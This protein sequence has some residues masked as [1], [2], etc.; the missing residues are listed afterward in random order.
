M[1]PAASAAAACRSRRGAGMSEDAVI[2]KC[3]WR[4]LPLIIVAYVFNYIDRTN[5]GFAA[6]TMNRDLGFSP[7][8]YG[9]GAGIFFVSYA[10]FQIPANLLLHR[11]GARRWMACI[12]MAWGAVAAA[13][14]L[15]RGAHSFYTVRFVLGAAEAGFFPGTIFYLSLWF[16]K[17][18]LGRMTAVFQ[19]ATTTSLV[20]GGPLASAILS[21]DGIAGM[22][23]WQW[24][25]LLEGLP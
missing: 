21:L 12:L 10:F 3:A 14:A 24:L 7:S 17:A 20:I 5:I 15:T 11:F 16:P 18:W 19:S 4:L 22:H 9:F 13:N 1:R 2:R 6:L 8:V 25:F 23:S